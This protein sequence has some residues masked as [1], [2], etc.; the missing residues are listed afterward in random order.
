MKKAKKKVRRKERIIRWLRG[1]YSY[2][3]LALMWALKQAGLT[4][5]DIPSFKQL[6]KDARSEG[7][8]KKSKGNVVSITERIQ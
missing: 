7:R 3:V 8:A 6:L 1:D 5:A 4:M 2:A